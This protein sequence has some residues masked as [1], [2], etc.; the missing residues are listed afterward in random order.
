M[1]KKDGQEPKKRVWE[2]DFL[3][4]VCIIMMVLDHLMFDLWYFPYFVSN[5][6]EI[7]NAAM[8]KV[9]SFA[10]RY[11]EWG[12][13][14]GVRFAVI[15]IFMMLS[16]ISCYFSRSNT[17]RLIKLTV[18][19]FVLSA[20]TIII[21]L[22]MDAGV[23]IYFGILFNLAA[24]LGIYI[25]LKKLWDNKYFFLGVGLALIIAGICINFTK[26]EYCSEFSFE[27]LIKSIIGL[28]DLGADSYGIV[29]YTGVFLVG[30]FLGAMLYGE[31]K[32]L[33]PKLEGKWSRPV[34]FVGRNTIWVYLAHQPIILGI[35]LLAGLCMGYRVF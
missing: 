35:V 29:P 15:F 5:F 34:E 28:C 7:D 26:V 1:R 24:S 22:F 31:K 6:Y 17:K 11:W 14:I 19:G 32:T 27:N 16:G 12:V 9:V 8:K 10:A 30:S 3:R 4:G 18:A 23:S 21:D 33:L 2:I 20:A 13:R 25:L